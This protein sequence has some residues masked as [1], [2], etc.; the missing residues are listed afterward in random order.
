MSEEPM[1]T[2][3]YPQT[4]CA[5]CSAR[6]GGCAGRERKGI[7]EGEGKG[8]Q[9]SERR[10]GGEEEV[11]EGGVGASRAVSSLWG[12]MTGEPRS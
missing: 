9:G 4:G 12:N 1:Y 10:D 3:L 5:V 6:K 8:G 11:T 7:G 2:G